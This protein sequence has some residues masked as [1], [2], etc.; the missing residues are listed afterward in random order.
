MGVPSLSWQTFGFWYKLAQ[1]KKFPHLQSLPRPLQRP[2]IGSPCRNRL[3]FSTFTCPE[4]VL[5][6]LSLKI[7]M[8]QK[9]AFS[10]PQL[11]AVHRAVVF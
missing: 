11:H 1:K 9:K 2:E 4:H 5:G 10:A 8:A 6:E 7:V 3:F